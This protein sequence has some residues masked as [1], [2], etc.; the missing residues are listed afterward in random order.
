MTSRTV[1]G[2][3]IMIGIKTRS[4]TPLPPKV[5]PEEL[6]PDEQFY[7]RLGGAAGPL[8]RE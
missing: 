3:T 7:R 4:F 5:S 6:V 2:H 8:V 1:G